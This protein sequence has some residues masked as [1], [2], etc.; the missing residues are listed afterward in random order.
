MTPLD[1]GYWNG[2]AERLGEPQFQKQIA[3]SKR[4]ENI[5]LVAAWA[6]PGARRLLKTDVFEEAY[7]DDA[8]LDALAAF[9][10]AV[11][12]MDVSRTVAA[13]ARARWPGLP[14]LAA[15][16]CALPFRAASFDL[17]VSI[18][19]LDHLPPHLLPTALGQLRDVLKPGGCLILTL[20]SRHNP[21]HVFSNYLR[22]RMGR[23][24]AERCYTIGEVRAILERQAFVVTEATAIYH[25]QFP[26]NFLA[27]KL[28]RLLGARADPP[29]RW[30]VGMCRALGALPTRLL[31]GRYVAFRA[32]KA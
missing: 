17:I 7:G 15:D 13:A 25:V 19:T 9:C 22:R 3:L 24:Y 2:L 30:A 14:F 32:I 27:K 31:T 5:E 26:I 28:S 23:I 6:P 20:D 8:L 16:A 11:V 12:G 10:P 1:P 21:L 18:S 4:R 29:I